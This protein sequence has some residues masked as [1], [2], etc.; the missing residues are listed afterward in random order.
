MKILK[1]L[2]VNISN[3]L[4]YVDIPNKTHLNNTKQKC[5]IQKPRYNILP[6]I[7]ISFLIR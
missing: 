6:Y 4:D 7:L 1:I 5:E 2:R 3:E